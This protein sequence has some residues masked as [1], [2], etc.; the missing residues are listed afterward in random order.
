M[1]DERDPDAE[2]SPAEERVVALLG[3]LAPSELERPV[4]LAPRVVRRA[5]WQRALRNALEATGSLAGA[6]GDGLGF[7][8]GPSRRPGGP[9]P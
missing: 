6:V 2:R 3:L 1:S 5:R 4:D 7:L 9:R 8:V